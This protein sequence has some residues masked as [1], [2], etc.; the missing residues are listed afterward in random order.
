MSNKLHKAEGGNESY[1][2]IR[3]QHKHKE[4]ISIKRINQKSPLRL[5]DIDARAFLSKSV[6]WVWVR[7]S[8]LNQ[9]L[10]KAADGRQLQ[11][12]SERL[13]SRQTRSAGLIERNGP[14][15]IAAAIKSLTSACDPL[16]TYTEGRWMTG[17]VRIVRL[18]SQFIMHFHMWLIDCDASLI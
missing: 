6:T 11:R 2:F 1:K 5:Y 17:H 12:S 18:Y 9:I 15:H 16:F 7:V 13:R 4:K 3:S 14:V 10:I 8:G